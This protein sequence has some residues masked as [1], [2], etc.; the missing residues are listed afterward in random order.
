MLAKVS[1]WP[2]I[3][4]E[5]NEKKRALET[6]ISD[7]PPAKQLKSDTTNQKL[8]EHHESPSNFETLH[9]NV[10]IHYIPPDP[11]DYE[12][13]SEV[14]ERRV[15]CEIF[16]PN[17]DIERTRITVEC[18]F[19]TELIRMRKILF[20]HKWCFFF[21]VNKKEPEFIGILDRFIREVVITDNI[22]D[23]FKIPY[24]PTLPPFSSQ[25]DFDEY[26]VEPLNQLI[27][28]LNIQVFDECIIYPENYLIY[29]P[30]L[31]QFKN[32]TKEPIS[33]QSLCASTSATSTDDPKVYKP[34]F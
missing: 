6:E 26:Q 16:I 31:T 17:S 1:A 23:R 5:Q 27:K 15:E 18:V 33:D 34:I 20:H 2:D 9:H 11:N 13:E 32:E 7:Q 28:R 8:V 10:I 22:R 25:P 4:C 29:K 12:G 21:D 24:T 30:D 14:V 3:N 19:K